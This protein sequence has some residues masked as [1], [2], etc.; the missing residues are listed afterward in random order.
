MDHK[1]YQGNAREPESK[2]RA[3]YMSSAHLSR[4]LSPVAA[5]FTPSV[6][7]VRAGAFGGNLEPVGVTGVVGAGVLDLREALFVEPRNNGQP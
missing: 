7:A 4:V 3:S 6:L 2:A 5:N 1:Q